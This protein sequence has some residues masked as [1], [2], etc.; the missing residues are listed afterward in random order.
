MISVLTVSKRTGWEHIAEKCLKA[1]TYKDFEWVVVTEDAYSH[2]CLQSWGNTKV[3]HLLAPKKTRK[4]NLSASNNE[5]LRH[6]QGKYVVFYQDFIILPPDCLEKL[7]ALATDN[8]FVTTLTKNPEG[9]EEDPRYL[10]IDGPRPCM[11]EEWEE[12][13]GLAPMKILKELGGYDEEYDNG[14]AWN[15]VNIS[16][17]AEMLGCDFI[18]DESNRPQLIYHKKEPDLNPNM[19]LNGDFHNQRMKDIAEGKH[20][21]KNPY[22]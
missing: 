3:T 12:N 9:E 21:I 7:V 19:P 13:V 16:C 1:Q 20:P 4:S 11:P 8:T 18:C 14:W 10:W 6:C 15:N 5:G 22:L 17:R 2:S